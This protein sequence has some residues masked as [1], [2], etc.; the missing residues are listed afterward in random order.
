MAHKDVEANVC[1]LK[2]IPEEFAARNNRHYDGQQLK[3]VAG[4][5]FCDGTYQTG[6]PEFQSGTDIKDRVLGSA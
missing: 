3:V 5:A 2:E 1:K 4:P 6:T